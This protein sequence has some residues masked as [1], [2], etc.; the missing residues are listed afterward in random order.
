[1][2]AKIA[3][4]TS[5]RKKDSINVVVNN[6]F[7][8]VAFKGRP[9]AD[10]RPFGIFDKSA[11]LKNSVL[12]GCPIIP[13][14]YRLADEYGQVLNQYEKHMGEAI[15]QM[16][17]FFPREGILVDFCA[18][19]CSAAL[20]A[21]Y[22]NQRFIICV[23]RDENVLKYAEARLYAY[24][25]A[26]MQ[27]P[28]FTNNDDEESDCIARYLKPGIQVREKFDGNDP[29][30][31]LL[32]AAKIGL[33]V[34]KILILPHNIPRETMDQMAEL[35]NCVVDDKKLYLTSSQEQGTQLPVYGHWRRSARQ[36]TQAPNEITHVIVRPMYGESK[37][38]V[39][40]VSGKCFTRFAR[41]PERAKIED[42]EDA[43]DDEY[44][45]NCRV[46]EN[47]CGMDNIFKVA[48]E[49][50]H[51]IDVPEG[52]RVELFCK[53][54]FLRF[55]KSWRAIVPNA[56]RPGEGRRKRKCDVV[57]LSDS[58]EGSAGAGD[59]AGDAEVDPKGETKD[60]GREKRHPK[61]IKAS[62]S[63][64]SNGDVADEPDEAAGSDESDEVDEADEAES[65]ENSD[66][67]T[68]ADN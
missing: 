43:E 58:D 17:R 30:K 12:T 48:L 49:L 45:A 40:N 33:P 68:Y 29:Y 19:T 67:P 54:D 50:I 39:L 66:D 51:D 21:L 41:D 16:S 9:K 64:K 32:A 60:T 61:R 56:K 35:H 38:Y 28:W 15:E 27:S 22:M 57:E 62:D 52:E 26:M 31:P 6:H 42:G 55:S 24:L 13:A 37:P 65:D 10:G 59:D 44:V 20:A 2:N 7:W 8:I 46:V 4:L 5:R 23:D 18:G 36:Q 3:V 1:M 63:N 53:Y 14:H 11:T 34:G 47:K 25:W